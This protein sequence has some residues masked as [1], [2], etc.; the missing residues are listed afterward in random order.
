V[1]RAGE[2]DLAGAQV[3]VRVVGQ[4]PRQQQQ[5]VERRAQLVAHVGQELRLVLAGGGELLGL[6]LDAAPGRVDLHVLDL[7]V[8]VLLGELRAF[9][10]SSALVCCSSRSGLQ[11]S[12]QVLRLGEQLLGAPVGL[13]RADRDADGDDEAL[14]EGQV[15]LAERVTAP[16]SM[17]PRVRP[18]NGTGSTT[19]AAAGSRRP[20]AIGR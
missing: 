13:D 18:S 4:Q 8:A 20:R 16:N 19:T 3:L 15:Q 11:L 2:L 5:R 6:L 14:E 10:S 9:S 12:G 7:D 1:D 17:T